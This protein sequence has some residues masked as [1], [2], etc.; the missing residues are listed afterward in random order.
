MITETLFFLIRMA[1]GSSTGSPS[2][3]SPEFI[4]KLG[5]NELFCYYCHNAGD[6]NVMTGLTLLTRHAID[7][8]KVYFPSR[9]VIYG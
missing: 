5:S 8:G 7:E 1:F 9:D 6:L 3:T 4:R 2:D